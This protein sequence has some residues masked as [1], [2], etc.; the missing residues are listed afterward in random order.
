L[1]YKTIICILILSF[2]AKAKSPTESKTKSPKVNNKTALVSSVIDKKKKE[3]KKIL[4][5]PV[6]PEPY[7]EVVADKIVN[8]A[9]TIQQEVTR[10][11]FSLSDSLDEFFGE[12]RA[13]DEANQSTLRITQSNYFSERNTNKIDINANLNLRFRNLEAFGKKA[14]KKVTDFFKGDDDHKE[15]KRE[16][17]MTPSERKA[18]EIKDKE[19]SWN[20][21]WENRVGF[22]NRIH[23]WSTM[24]WRRSFIGDIFVHR[25]YEQ[26]GWSTLD[27]WQSV[28][29]LSSDKDL[30]SDLLFRFTNEFDWAMTYQQYTTIHGPSLIKAIDDRNS[31]SY[32]FRVIN[33][34]ENYNWYLNAYN[35]G[36]NYRHQTSKR[37]F[38]IQL[39]PQLTLARAHNFK[40]DLNITIT[41]EAVMGNF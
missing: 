32:D 5:I 1:R 35:I 37:W 7:I 17:E 6:S 18:K 28:T 23:A 13:L 9:E 3:K 15:D 21:N 30:D 24:R 2:A 8:S 29:S 10:R 27:E 25:F 19:E 41:F 40:R 14:E 20:F 34:L 38:F 11:V 22:T 39:T 36:L 4:K 31:I 12:K 16:D 33:G 26:V